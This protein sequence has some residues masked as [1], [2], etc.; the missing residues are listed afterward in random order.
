MPDFLKSKS[1]MQSPRS[2][3]A[4][5]FRVFVPLLFIGGACI[6]L[7][8]LFSARVAAHGFRGK[9]ALTATEQAIE[10]F[11]GIAANQQVAIAA[12][13]FSQ[14]QKILARFSFLTGLPLIG[15]R[16]KIANQFFL[17]AVTTT[18]AIKDITMVAEKIF[19]ALNISTSADTLTKSFPDASTLFRELTLA[20]KQQI[21]ATIALSA[22]TM[23]DA[24]E[25]ITSALA[26]F[27]LAMQNSVS[28]RFIGRLTPLR[29]KLVSA[30]D[31]LSLLIPL[32]RYAP[33]LLAFGGTKNY[34]L[35][36]ENNTE[37]RPSGGFLGVYGLVT[38]ANA[39]ITELDS[40]DVYA[41]DG[42]SAS[43]VRPI[44]P[45]PLKKYL[46][47]T[48]WYLRD[49]NWSPDFPTSAQNIQKLYTEEYALAKGVS[50]PPI[51]GVIGLTPAIVQGVLAMTG[52]ITIDGSTFTATNL[53]DELEYQVEKGFSSNG[54][55]FVQRKDIVKKLFQ[56]LVDRLSN[57][58][59]AQ[60]RDV[61]ILVQQN[62]SEGQ[63]T[64]SF[65]DSALQQFVLDNDWGGKMKPVQGDYLS[66]ID[67]NL[68]SLKSDPVVQRSIK[69][70]IMP[71][72]ASYEGLVTMQYRNTGSFTWK[73]TRYRTYTRVYVPLGST[74]IRASGAMENDKLKD[75]ARRPGIVDVENDLGRTS[76]G[77]FISIEPG[78]SKE[79]QFRFSLSPGVVAQI[80][81]GKYFLEVEKQLGTPANG[82]TL[83]LGFGKKLT[84][85]V[86][87]EAPSDFGD[88]RYRYSTDLRVDRQFDIRL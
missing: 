79:L 59:L 30:R 77:A 56:T 86:P 19:L 6:A 75:P 63:I 28:Q 33:S 47:V 15:P 45:A 78:E 42:P 70:Q 83:D 68:A 76:F 58:S 74:L 60:L 21:L 24:Q 27:D 4:S 25:K 44:H 72:G 49:A 20:Q 12:K 69:Y 41:L 3:A 22:P 67:A 54:I 52:P 51:D 23:I 26:S 11:D 88:A 65:T 57:F 1:A 50:S 7:F 10:R 13:E 14:G 80:Q 46:G 16:L 71:V 81:Q 62:L 17:T 82:L 64:F 34:L 43:S 36:F 8:M 53:V 84:G 55:P 32:S 61:A 9:A 35:F 85:A 29:Q 18:A 38:V 37:L 39:T 73:T 2:P 31:S 40:S 48:K 87:S 66:V 5:S